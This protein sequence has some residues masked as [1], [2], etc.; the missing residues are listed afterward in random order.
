MKLEITNGEY[1][2]MTKL[3][4]KILYEQTSMINIINCSMISTTFESISLFK[5][6]LETSILGNTLFQIISSISHEE[7]RRIKNG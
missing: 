1:I 7:H 5:G 4:E 2:K 3:E 6:R